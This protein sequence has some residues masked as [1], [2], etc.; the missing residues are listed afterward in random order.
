MR[1]LTSAGT[2]RS[3][4]AGGSS[5]PGRSPRF[6]GRVALPSLAAGVLVTLSIPPFGFWPL[7]P[8]GLAVLYL[9]IAGLNPGRRALA[10]FVAGLGLYGP[11][12]YWA[13]GFT[14]PGW[15][16][17]VVVSALIVAAACLLTPPAAGRALAFPAALTL[18]ELLRST[19]PFGGYPVGSLPLG[20]AAG[21]LG[22]P[23][24]LG[25]YLL[26][27]GLVAL[28]AVALA[29]IR[30]GRALPAVAAAGAAVTLVLAGYL[31]PDGGAGV[32][33]LHAAAVQGG[34][35][36]GL[37]QSQVDPAV[38]YGAQRAASAQIHEPVGL[39]LWPEDVISLTG[40]LRGTTEES[41]MSEM[42]RS[43]GATVVAGVT[44]DVGATQFQ[45]QAVAWGPSGAITDVY[46][47]VHRVPFGEYVPGRFIFRHLAN[48]EDVPRDAIP[49]RGP[50]ILHTPAGRL[51][52]MVSYEVFFADRGR[53]AVAAGA[54]LLIVPTNTS[55]Y[56]SGQL[57]A[58]EIAA[59]RLR[60][61]EE[62][63]DLVQAAP[64]GYSAVIDNR[65]SVVRRGP[66][67]SRAVLV[68]SVEPRVGRTLYS[69]WGDV[70]V[71]VAGGVLLAGGWLRYGRLRRHR[72]EDGLRPASR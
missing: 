59:S 5:Q 58:Q 71:V 65:G 36:R 55:S 56:S 27:T 23:A 33:S 47:K 34:G 69:R 7:G 44:E 63:R 24:R 12:L 66:L 45:N 60:A 17:F 29:E 37:R 1:Q 2:A 19:W 38:V 14:V 30:D 51:G 72:R 42:A 21:P 48:L 11:S 3:D 43:L 40:P 16:A 53:S 15:M 25:G 4:P 20:Q 32:S 54:R 50:A 46:E 6:N 57:P 61:V 68:A 39:V 41:Q 49:G 35:Q 28:T 22:S 18:A 52:V 8:I 64:T 67:G 62:G 9:R 26:V 13:T 10:G 31:A 70:P